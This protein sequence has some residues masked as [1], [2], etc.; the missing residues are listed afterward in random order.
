MCS[1]D[2]CRLAIIALSLAAVAGPALVSSPAKTLQASQ[3][4]VTA[5]A[6]DSIRFVAH[7]EHIVAGFPMSARPLALKNPLEGNAQALKVGAQLFIGYNCIDCHGADG[8]GAMAPSL[9]D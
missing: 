9:A 7:A 6:G 5:P 1:S 4:S 2:R 3:S 8:S